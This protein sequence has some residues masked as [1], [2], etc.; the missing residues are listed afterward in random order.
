[1]ELS[2]EEQ[3]K[4]VNANIK[5]VEIESYGSII[6]YRV[7]QK[8]SDKSAMEQEKFFLEKLEKMKLEYE[9]IIK[10]LE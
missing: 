7:A 3:V 5:Q 6:R 10:E 9:A 2:K 1:M 4:V 8:V